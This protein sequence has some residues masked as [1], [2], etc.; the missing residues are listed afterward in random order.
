MNV[1]SHDVQNLNQYRISNGIE[2]LVPVFAVHNNL[3]VSQNCQVLR[4]IRLFEA[5][6]LLDSPRGKLAIAQQLKDSNAGGMRECAKDH[7]RNIGAPLK[8]AGLANM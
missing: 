4:E 1:P 8:A 5:E 6:F 3:V 7:A 2:H